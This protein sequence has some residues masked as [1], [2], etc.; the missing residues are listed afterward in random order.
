MWRGDVMITLIL[1]PTQHQLIIDS[2]SIAAERMVKNNASF[3]ADQVLALRNEIKF[4]DETPGQKSLLNQK[5]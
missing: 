2:L 1:T 4:D 5:Y 3:M